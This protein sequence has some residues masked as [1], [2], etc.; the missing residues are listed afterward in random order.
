MTESGKTAHHCEAGGLSVT[1]GFPKSGDSMPFSCG[2]PA[3]EPPAVWV[4]RVQQRLR[5]PGARPS[6]PSATHHCGCASIH[7]AI[8]RSVRAQ[9]QL[10]RLSPAALDC[11]L[12]RH[13]YLPRLLRR[14]VGGTRGGLCRRDPSIR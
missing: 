12:G 3:A 2:P 13:V 1:D 6:A 7:P 11:D 5:R 4:H 10:D 9:A 8:G 14:E